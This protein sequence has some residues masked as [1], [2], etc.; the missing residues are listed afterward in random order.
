MVV[1]ILCLWWG[2]QQRQC[3]TAVI[4]SIFYLLASD[5]SWLS[6]EEPGPGR[7]TMG[8]RHGDKAAAT[9]TSWLLGCLL[10]TR[11]RPFGGTGGGWTPAVSAGGTASGG[12]RAGTVATT[13]V[14]GTAAAESASGIS[15][16]VGS[17]SVICRRSTISIISR[18]TICGRSLGSLVIGSI[19]IV[20]VIRCSV[21]VVRGSWG[22]SI[23]GIGSSRRGSIAISGSYFIILIIIIGGSICASG[24]SG[25]VIRA[26]GRGSIAVIGS[27]G[28]T[29]R[30]R[31]R[32]AIGIISS[33]WY[34]IVVIII[35]IL[36]TASTRS[37]IRVISRSAGGTIGVLSR[38]STISISGSC[39]WGT[40][41]VIGV[42]IVGG[43]VSS[44]STVRVISSCRRGA[45]GVIGRCSVIISGRGGIS[46][47]S[48]LT[49]VSAAESTSTATAWGESAASWRCGAVV[50]SVSESSGDGVL[51]APAAVVVV[52][53]SISGHKSQ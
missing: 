42:V 29:I 25:A 37:A 39:G 4:V 7:T 33:S 5:G 21:A 2:I 27:G 3:G 47:V 31:R 13:K 30:V 40:I 50:A 44:G 41:V 15:G 9:S 24:S 23:A 45:V 16:L 22:C 46:I 35:S 18:C 17:S 48:L 1:V 11:G 53:T 43:C 6:L 10:A 34:F 14:S 20:V 28:T 12:G 8:H 32:G 52:G 49:A 26:S 51:A 36:I 19:I 38:G